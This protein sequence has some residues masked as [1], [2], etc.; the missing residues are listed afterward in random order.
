MDSP[1]G[2]SMPYSLEAEQAV[3]ASAMLN[4][5]ATTFTSRPTKRSLT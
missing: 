5:N 4:E 1:I 2:V 3:L